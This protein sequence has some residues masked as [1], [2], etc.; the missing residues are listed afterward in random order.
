VGA[1]WR[2]LTPLVGAEAFGVSEVKSQDASLE[3]VF[4]YLIT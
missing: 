4:D 1:F 3:A 2:R